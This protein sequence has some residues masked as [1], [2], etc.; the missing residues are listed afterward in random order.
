RSEAMLA[1]DRPRSTWLRKL[2]LR[3]ERSAIVRSV[4][5]RKRRS[6]RS[7]SPTSTSAETSGALDGIQFSLDPV[8]EKLKQPYD[9][10]E[11]A[12]TPTARKRRPMRFNWR[13]G[14]SAV[15]ASSLGSGGAVAV[16]GVLGEP[17]EPASEPFDRGR[18]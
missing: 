11:V 16:A 5:R 14:S 12:S 8:E 1:L 17:R 4:Q 10:R 18:G 7:R 3:P 6:A 15:A 13:E 2:S 9:S